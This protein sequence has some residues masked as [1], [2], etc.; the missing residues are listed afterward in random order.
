MTDADEVKLINGLTTQVVAINAGVAALVAAQQ[1]APGTTT[2]EEDAA[3]AQLQTAISGLAAI[4]PVP[5]NPV[6]D[7]TP[8]AG[9]T[10][11]NPTP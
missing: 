9:D 11:N 1:A 6:S 4:V 3:V 8:A 5:S 10:A 7:Q 2:P